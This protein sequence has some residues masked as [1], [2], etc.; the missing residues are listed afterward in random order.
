[1]ADKRNEFT[2]A[3][4][5]G[6]EALSSTVLAYL[7]NLLVG[8]R[9]RDRHTSEGVLVALDEPWFRRALWAW[10]EEN[11]DKSER[12]RDALSSLVASN[13]SKPTRVGPAPGLVGAN[14]LKLGRMLGLDRTDRAILQFVMAIR[15]VRDFEPVAAHYGPLTTPAAAELVAV[16]TGEPTA[17]VRRALDAD[18][19]LMATGLLKVDPDPEPLFAKLLPNIRL[20]DFVTG[21]RLD[22]GVLADAFARSASPPSLGLSDFG[23]VDAAH[24]RLR[25]LLASALDLGTSGVHV[26]LHGPTGSGKS[27][28]GRLLARELGADAREPRTD[29]VDLGGARP[30]SRL[31]ALL[32]ADRIIGGRTLLLLDDA[33]ELFEPG[34][35]WNGARGEPRA[36]RSWLYRALERN[37]SP[38]IWTVRDPAMLDAATFRRFALVMELPAL[39]EPRRLSLWRREAEGSGAHEKALRLMA[40]RLPASPAEISAA[41]R[42][43]RAITG[44]PFDPAVAEAL[45]EAT[46]KAT[47]GSAPR[48]LDATS[49]DYVVEAL[50]ASA[51]LEAIA[52][53]LGTSFGRGTSGVTLCLHGPS[54]TGK[55]QWVRHLAERLGRQLHV[56]RVADIESKWVGESEKA[57]A[58]AFDAAER[59]GAVLLFDEADSFL[60][61][62]G[63]TTH[64]WEVTLTNEFLQRLESARAI[65][66][67]TTNCFDDLDAAVLRR[68]DLKIAFDYLRPGQAVRLFAAVFGPFLGGAAANDDVP[69]ARRLEAVGPLAP[70]DFA[71]VARR[72]RLLGRRVEEDWLLAELRSEVSARA[73]HRAR[74]AGFRPG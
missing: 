70:G 11:P 12:P 52:T 4:L 38:V 35:P 71:T 32:A 42:A 53:Q 26:L 30:W 29:A 45:L 51:D 34:A 69:L 24:D 16:A 13:G 73:P 39:D 1:M 19:R 57:V 72:A 18:G 49:S 46:L 3:A 28:F 41:A 9:I 8:T 59:E 68:F 6:A 27:E 14:F 63:E 67:C 17:A 74:T 33:E 65:V 21:P 55:S 56:Q 48:A 15:L 2:T 64:R 31:A 60:R 62:R 54:G 43:T 10:A 22:A 44:G 23:H 25:R 50:N 58:R 36:P 20:P 37:R 5:D 61:D 66:A 40:R 7:L 47:S